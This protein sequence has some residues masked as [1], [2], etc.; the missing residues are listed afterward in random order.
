LKIGLAYP[1]FFTSFKSYYPELEVIKDTSIENI[2]TYDLIIFS[3]GEDISP[4]FYGSSTSKSA[5]FDYDSPRDKIE[6][7]IF[8]KAYCLNKKILGVCR[9]HQLIN[10]LIY[11]LG[12]NFIQDLHI[13]GYKDHHSEHPLRII[14]PGII[15]KFFENVN[16]YHHQG[17]ARSAMMITSMYENVVES[18]ES[19]NIITVQ[20]HPEFMEKRSIPFFEAIKEWANP[21]KKKEPKI[22]TDHEQYL[23]SLKE[24]EKKTR[25]QVAPAVEFNPQPVAATLTWDNVYFGDHP[26]TDT[27]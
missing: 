7:E 18:C 21:N 5:G 14:E 26:N 6:S 23:K 19:D 24:K 1:P 25:I 12:S 11:S 8:R 9:G 17:I 20:F 15:S 3:G 22:L 27:H 13:C 10:C 4:S 16:S 2:N